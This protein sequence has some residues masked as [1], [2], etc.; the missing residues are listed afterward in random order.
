R[1][2]RVRLPGQHPRLRELLQQ[3]APRPQLPLRPLHPHLLL[4]PGWLVPPARRVR[5]PPVPGVPT[6]RWN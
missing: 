1:L 4:R 2:P 5:L 3:L 6:R